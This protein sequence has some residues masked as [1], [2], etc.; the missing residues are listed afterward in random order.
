MSTDARRSPTNSR[1]RV[2]LFRCLAVCSPI[3]LLIVLE[4]AF[5]LFGV[6]NPDA[7]QD[8]FVGFSAV[9]P[10][11]V[12]QDDTHV[13]A[14]SRLDF[15]RKDSFAATKSANTKRIFCLGG[16]T[17]QGRP[18]SLDTAFPRCLQIAL[19]Q[20]T[21]YDWEVVNCGGISYASYRLVPVLREVLQYEPDA[22]IVC[23]GHNEFLED[24][25][26]GHL[27]N[28]NWISQSTSRLRSVTLARRFFGTPVT[29]PTDTLPAEV[30]AMLDYR[31][32]LKKYHR[33]PEWC[34]LVARHFEDN[35]QRMFQ[36]CAQ[37]NV[38]LIFVQ[39]TWD[40][41]DTRPFKSEHGPIDA[42]EL[43][44]W[45][46][47]VAQARDCVATDL[48]RA[49]AAYER[50]VAI[51][52]LYAETRFELGKCYQAA[53]RLDDAQT[54]FQTALETD[55]CPLRMP[56][57]LRAAMNN[58][59]QQHDCGFLNAQEL[60]AAESSHGML[61]R[62]V[63]VDHIHPSFRGHFLIGQALAPLVAQSLQ[64]SL[65]KDWRL[66][67]EK[68]WQAHFQSLNSQYFLRGQ[69]SLEALKMWTQGKADPAH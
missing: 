51:D 64:L 23:T 48:P 33:D 11:F 30:D 21:E 47:F 42:T 19:Q 34:A 40:Q 63:L 26:Y 43:A 67:A 44:K 3:V 17:V 52:P 55:V 24:R 2:L 27:R 39:P 46:R 41:V 6:G 54:E 65:A 7:L 66:A 29:K 56:E 16:S 5:R 59:V 22:I 10:L 8:P 12:Q 31:E 37:A 15:F 32:G 68:R 45:E 1:K 9:Q 13:T 14:A 36:L 57:A 18:W 4:C 38:R 58:V 50:A 20:A 25:T 69:R 28:T 49:I 60:L 61:D 35:L 62:A 53:N